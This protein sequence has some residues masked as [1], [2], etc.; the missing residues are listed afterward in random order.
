MIA[1]TLHTGRLV[2][3]QLKL[4]DASSLFDVLSDEQVMHF[5]SSGPH[6]DIDETRNYIGWNADSTAD[7]VCWAITQDGMIAVGWVILLPRRSN[8]FELGYI[9]GRDQ[10]RNGYVYEA[11]RAVI[12]F[13]FERI[14]A[15]RI[16]ADTDPENIAS[17]CLLEKLGFQREGHLREEWETHIG[18]RDSLIFGLL[19]SEWNARKVS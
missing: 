12:D 19:R 17:V 11:V 18:I 7:H 2:L 16:M 6:K 8:N 1:P 9:L 4:D 14:G 15:R 5:W 3:R 13:A 10:W